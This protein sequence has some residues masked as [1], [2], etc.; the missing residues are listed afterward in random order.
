[1]L[2]HWREIPVIVQQRVAMLDT[3]G[4]D[5]EVGRLADRDAQPP[6]RTIIP[7]GVR[8]EIG[9]QKR[10]ERIPAQSAFDA[11][12]MGLIP[13]ALENLEQNEVADQE[14]LTTGGGFQLRGCERSMA[15]QMG[16]PDG[17]VDKN[18][19]RRGWRP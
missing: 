17:A 10:H 1:M 4:A 19:N 18:H 3:E 6:Q 5:D 11:R 2:L 9:I 12:S 8:R 16:D 14:R 7:R 15:A 13:G